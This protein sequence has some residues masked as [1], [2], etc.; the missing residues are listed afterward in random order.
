MELNTILEQLKNTR[1]ITRDCLN[2]VY[3]TR[4]DRGGTQ[5]EGTTVI[6]HD[7]TVS[8][9]RF[10]HAQVLINRLLGQL[11]TL[12]EGAI[13]ERGNNKKTETTTGDDAGNVAH[14]PIGRDLV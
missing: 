12:V 2:Q 10:V 14:Q 13:R 7:V 8:C 4:Q 3:A 9:G 5:V 6:C 11:Q 1:N